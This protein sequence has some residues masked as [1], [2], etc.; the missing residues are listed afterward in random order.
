MYVCEG[1]YL[2][3]EVLL[4]RAGGQQRGGLLSVPLAVVCVLHRQ[5][6]HI[7]SDDTTYIHTCIPLT[8]DKAEGYVYG[9]YTYIII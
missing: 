2:V 8:G 6:L 4:L 7:E 9:T 1:V 3:C 5:R